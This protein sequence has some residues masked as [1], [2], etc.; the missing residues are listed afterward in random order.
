MTTNRRGLLKVVFWT[1]L[2][3]VWFCAL[4]EVH[5]EP[6]KPDFEVYVVSGT[7]Y[8]V[9]FRDGVPMP[10][11]RYT[12]RLESQERAVVLVRGREIGRGPVV[13]VSAAPRAVRID[14]H[15]GS[16]KVVVQP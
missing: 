13:E 2:C 5:A 16:A 3:A 8:A 11:G 6:G 15:P 12:V 9:V 1:V 4:A 14:I 7:R 10:F